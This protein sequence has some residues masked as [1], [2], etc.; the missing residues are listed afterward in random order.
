MAAAAP[1]PH[2]FQLKKDY[3]ITALDGTEWRIPTHL[4]TIVG[5]RDFVT[6]DPRNYGLI[7]LVSSGVADVMVQL[8]Y[9]ESWKTLNLSLSHTNG[10]EW[11]KKTRCDAMRMVMDVDTDDDNEPETAGD[12]ARR[13]ML[14]AVLQRPLPEPVVREHVVDPLA[15]NHKW[16][17]TIE[18]AIC[19]DLGD[20]GTV[21][22]VANA[23]KNGA[24]KV[25]LDPDHI[26]AI[27]LLLQYGLCYEDMT[28]K[29]SYKRKE[30]EP[31]GV[32]VVGEPSDGSGVKYG[33]WK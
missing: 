28:K 10:F 6:L 33:S 26:S 21:T 16:H 24:I 25:L 27:I 30:P 19:V 8:P 17:D 3:R 32:E 20:W 2:A 7:K 11:V 29:R 12:A 31:C 13:E 22:V 4:L 5:G 15:P 18:D 23:R 1:S 14:S 9:D